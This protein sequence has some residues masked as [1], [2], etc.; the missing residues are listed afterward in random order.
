MAPIP[1]LQFYPDFCFP[2]SPAS[3]PPATSASFLKDKAL[4]SCLN[5]LC[6]EELQQEL[7]WVGV[8]HSARSVTWEMVAQ[9]N[10][11]DLPFFFFYVFSGKEPWYFDAAKE[12]MDEMLVALKAGMKTLLPALL[13][14]VRGRE[15][16]FTTLSF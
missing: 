13:P 3:Q 1:S 8:T 2:S 4:L 11:D 6:A 14:S 5:A 15:I 9:V 7:V 12:S 16:C 10:I